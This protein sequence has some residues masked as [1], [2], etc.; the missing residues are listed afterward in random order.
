M[1]VFGPKQSLTGAL[2]WWS[3]ILSS[4][5]CWLWPKQ[6]DLFNV[7]GHRLLRLGVFKSAVQR[8]DAFLMSIL[9]VSLL[10][11]FEPCNWLMQFVKV[12]FLG[13]HLSDKGTL[14]ERPNPSLPT[15]RRKIKSGSRLRV[16]TT[17]GLISVQENLCLSFWLSSSK[18]KFKLFWLGS[19]QAKIVGSTIPDM[20]P[21][22]RI[23]YCSVRAEPRTLNLIL[24]ERSHKLDFCNPSGWAGSGNQ[25]NKHKVSPS[26]RLW[27]H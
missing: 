5:F 27:H 24:V 12:I 23:W 9:L 1:Y 4:L 11:L 20:S 21:K 22:A 13:S 8:T 6:F 14:K 3:L 26:N 17:F 7:Q 2:V 15:Q 19:A 16:H 25:S 18:L 10:S